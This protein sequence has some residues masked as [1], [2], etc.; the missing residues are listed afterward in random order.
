MTFKLRFPEKKITYWANRA[1]DITSLQKIGQAAR[2]RGYLT[3]DEFLNLCKVK[4]PRSKSRCEKNTPELIKEITAISS[5]AK[6]EQV[7][8][9]SLII[10]TGVS[11]PTASFI[12]HFCSK[13]NYPIL[14]YRALWS[15]SI[16]EPPVYAFEFWKKYTAHCR[17]LAERNNLSMR[18]L[19]SALWQYSKENQ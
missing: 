2:A 4:S 11:W 14:D 6:S 5:C 3:K 17:A 13:H 15:L 18:C 9:Q 19:D 8:I 16:D 7:E 12:L 10:L 1:P